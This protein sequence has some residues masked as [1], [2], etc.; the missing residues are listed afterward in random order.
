MTFD[1]KDVLKDIILAS[2]SPRRSELLRSLGLSVRVVPS[3]YA[4]PPMP[5]L[6]P[7][8]LAFNHAREKACD[9]AHAFSK[10]VVVAADT[11]VD[12]DGE[13]LGK[14]GDAQEA[15]AMLARLSGRTHLVHTSFTLV[16]GD[17]MITHTESTIVQFFPMEASSIAAYVA[18]GEPFDKAGGYGIQ[19]HGA[20]FVER[21]EGDFY[22]VMGFPLA[23]FSRAVEEFG[24]VLKP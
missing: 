24:F 13:A 14:P 6:T 8:E 22:T 4:E 16:L 20:L 9:V 19:G 3:L 21:I 18:S 10:H 5:E 15:V 17:R 23:R 2:A 7:A 11:V 12:I 1:G